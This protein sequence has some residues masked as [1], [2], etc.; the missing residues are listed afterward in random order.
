M[1]GIKM[2]H[3]INLNI[4]YTM[5][6]NIWEKV[7]RVYASMRYWAGD[8]KG[9]C[10][11]A[12]NIDLAVSVEPG[13]LQIYGKMPEEIW[14]SWYSELKEKLSVALGYEIGEPED[15]YEFPYY[16]SDIFRQ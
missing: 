9:P 5:P 16:D 2:N 10:W 13:G 14:E 4:H 1:R 6:D 3:S 11:K 7:S 15:G 12:E 8:K